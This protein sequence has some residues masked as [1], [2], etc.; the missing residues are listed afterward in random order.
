MFVVIFAT[1]AGYEVE[2]LAVNVERV[3]GFE[4]GA[5]MSRDGHDVIHQQ[6]NVGEDGVVNVLQHVVGSIPF[7][8]YHV[9]GVDETVS[10]G[11]YFSDFAFNLEMG[12]NLLQFFLFHDIRM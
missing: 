7:G 1:L 8:H 6:V 12:G 11:L 4:F 9:S 10:E 3:D 5:D 2:H